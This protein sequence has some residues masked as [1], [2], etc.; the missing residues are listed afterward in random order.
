[1]FRMAMYRLDLSAVS[2]S[3]LT[4]ALTSASPSTLGSWTKAR[5]DWEP[6]GREPVVA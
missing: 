1:M 6:G 2:K 5:P 4:E 3:N